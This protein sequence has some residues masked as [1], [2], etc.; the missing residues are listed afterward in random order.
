MYDAL[1]FPLVVEPITILRLDH[2][3]QPSTHELKLDPF[4]NNTI[5]GNHDMEPPLFTMS[6]FQ[7][8]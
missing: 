5:F 2:R 4:C 6:R 1:V 8:L 7:L 3:F